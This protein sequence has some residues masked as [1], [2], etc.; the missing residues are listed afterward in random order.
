M[1]E[2]QGRS[3]YLRKR[4]LCCWGRSSFRVRGRVPVGKVAEVG[5]NLARNGSVTEGKWNS[6]RTFKRA[7]RNGYGCGIVEATESGLP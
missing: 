1:P 5:G 3:H 7:R 6:D 4:G 2:G